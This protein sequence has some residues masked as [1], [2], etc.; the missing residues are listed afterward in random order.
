MR[1]SRRVTR[2]DQD[3]DIQKGID[4]SLVFETPM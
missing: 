2:I 4:A 3:I 1:E